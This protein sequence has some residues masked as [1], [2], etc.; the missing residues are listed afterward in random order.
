MLFIF[1]IVKQTVF[2]PLVL[3]PHIF[4]QEFPLIYLNNVYHKAPD[5]SLYYLPISL[6]NG[7]SHLAFNFKAPCWHGTDG[8][9]LFLLRLAFAFAF[10]LRRFTLVKCKRKRKCKRKKMTLFPFLALELAFAF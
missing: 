2:G 8:A 10:A 5:I 9:G 7:R 1:S 4:R 6:L 3:L